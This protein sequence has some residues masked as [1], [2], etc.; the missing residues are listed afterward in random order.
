MSK[1]TKPLATLDE[2]K[3]MVDIAASWVLFWE[4]MARW[5]L[6]LLCVNAADF[7]LERG[8]ENC[9]EADHIYAQSGAWKK[10]RQVDGSESDNNTVRMCRFFKGVRMIYDIDLQ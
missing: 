10:N 6:T 5:R 4:V 9:V 8:V 2:S 7:L 1:W 3:D